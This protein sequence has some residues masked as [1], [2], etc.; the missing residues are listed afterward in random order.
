MRQRIY[1]I[2][3]A[4]SFTLDT[5]EK[6]SAFVKRVKTLNY[7]MKLVEL[8]SAPPGVGMRFN[9]RRHDSRATELALDIGRSYERRED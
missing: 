5:P 9:S 6:L 8:V 2:L 7:A 4:Q 3:E 1:E